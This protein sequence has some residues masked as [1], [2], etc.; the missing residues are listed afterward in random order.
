MQWVTPPPRRSSDVPALPPLVEGTRLSTTARRRSTPGRLLVA[1]TVAVASTA[2]AAGVGVVALAPAAQAVSYSVTGVDVASWQHPN[3]AAINWSRVKGA[4]YDF[5]IVKAT[6]STT[7]TNPYYAGDIAGAR[8]AG[9][10]IGSYHY[11]RPAMPISTA[12]AQ[13]RAFV[14]AIGTQQLS[15]T[16]PPI[17][18]IEA[19]GG[20][21]KANLSKWMTEFLLTVRA[22]TGRTPMI[23]SYDNFLRTS[24]GTP[25]IFR[26]YPLWYANYT[27]AP[28][29]TRAMPGAW[30]SWT[31]W[32]HSS[33]ASVPGISGRTDVNRYNGTM[34]SFL[35][36]ASGQ[37]P[38]K[39]S[40]AYAQP[41]ETTRLT[42]RVDKAYAGQIVARLDMVTKGKGKKKVTTWKTAATGRVAA[43]GTFGFSVN[44]VGLGAH[45]YRL[46]LASSSPYAHVKGKTLTVTTVKPWVKTLMTKTKVKR[47][48]T[49]LVYG[50]VDSMYA[51][52]RV[53]R[54][55]RTASGKWVSVA[56]RNTRADG[57]YAFSVRQAKKGTYSYRVVLR[58]TGPKANA[59]GRT[60]K[61]RVS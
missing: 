50:S 29:I 57:T 41:R 55:K 7:Y 21:S 4:G 25:E 45:S 22:G 23:Y 20:L 8:A 26:G 35:D 56:S 28:A 51:G 61:L 58:A 30:P 52:E 54:Q 12:T 17:L 44:P 60:V 16:L 39:I 59:D 53:W 2:T 43:D 27:T 48:K 40:Q 42:G 46:F 47:N 10:V 37:V 38:S 11:A 14:A 31:I 49:T 34:G 13:A 32:Q 5:A 1:L 9:L 36:F 33:T 6:E 19:T 24:V 3:G 15:R 18:D